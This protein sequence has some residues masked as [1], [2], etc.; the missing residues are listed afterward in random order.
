MAE[1]AARLL[2]ATGMNQSQTLQRLRDDCGVHW[3]VKK[4]RQVSEAVSRAMAEERQ[5]TQA[6]KLVEWLTQASASSGPH[7]PVLSVGRDG[8]T[9]DP[10]QGWLALRGGEDGHGECA[11]SPWS[12]I[13]ARSTWPTR[14]NRA[15]RR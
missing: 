4:L 10:M 1:R 12:A 15:S 3:G 13:W 6:A 9:V 5:E 7:K 14:R 2:S 8:I 11:G